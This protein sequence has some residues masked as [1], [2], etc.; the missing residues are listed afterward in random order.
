MKRLDR[1]R[2]VFCCRTQRADLSR[3]VFIA[4]EHSLKELAH[5]KE[6]LGSRLNTAP[7]AR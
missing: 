1:F 4:M 7:S 5:A 2:Y 6:K 3:D